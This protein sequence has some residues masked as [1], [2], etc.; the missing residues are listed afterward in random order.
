MDTDTPELVDK[1]AVRLEM[2]ESAQ[3]SKSDQPILDR[4]ACDE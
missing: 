4:C 3:K 2:N 1:L